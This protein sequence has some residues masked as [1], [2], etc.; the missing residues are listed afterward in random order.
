MKTFEEAIN[1]IGH[2]GSA[3]ELARVNE[4]GAKFSSLQ[5]EIQ[6]SPLTLNLFTS[7]V[8][9]ENETPDDD[10]LDEKGRLFRFWLVGFVTGVKI[11]IEMEKN[12]T[13]TPI[14]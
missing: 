5:C 6:A 14:A 8:E 11:G 4:E 9:V 2:D 3:S 10:N 13:A 7:Q 1:V 12:D